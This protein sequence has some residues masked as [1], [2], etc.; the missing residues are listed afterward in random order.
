M[1]TI[2]YLADAS[3]PH[4]IKWCNYFK[5]KGYDV[6]VISLNEG[7]IE[8]VKVYNFGF[9]VKELKN[10]SPFRKVK[11]I[12]VIG[13]IKKIIN[14]IK[15]DILHAH[16]AS[17][18]GL[19]GSLL[20]YKPYVISVWGTDIYDFP[21]GGF[22]QKLIIKHNLKK[23][24]Y[25][26][27]TSK[28]MARETNKYTDKKIY[29]TPFGIDIDVFKSMKIEENTTIE[30]PFIIGTIKTLEK[31]YG[32]NYLIRAFKLVKDQYKDKKIV[33]KIAGSGSQMDNL[34][35]LTKE[36]GID[37][38]VDFLGR[39]PLDEVSKT[40]NTFDIAVFPSLRESF[41]V[42]ALEAQ[43]CEI[44]AI[45]TN[46]G[47][48]PEVVLNNK[49]GII[50]ESE[51]EEQLKDAIIKLLE[52]QDLRNNMGKTGRKFVKENYEVNLNFNDI[53]KIYENIINKNI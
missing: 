35:N 37:K 23:A 31:K 53:E 21:N 33:L 13:E 51:N 6:N 14:E 7:S 43:A 9:N 47:G 28:D 50:V 5:S 46:V 36:L 27:S 41:G 17:S 44:P 42:A 19:I 20:N 24:D 1:S 52:N 45:V 3:N 26:F 11:Y 4:T 18:Y 8:G 22:I 48:H 10:A 12:S 32:I 34:L 25:I 49:S 30:K 29:I 16:Y 40:F 38:D 2:C 15:P 39:L